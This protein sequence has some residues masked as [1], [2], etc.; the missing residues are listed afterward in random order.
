[1]NFLNT[2][3]Y[4]TAVCVFQNHT[5]QLSMLCLDMYFARS[6][7]NAEGICKWGLSGIMSH[8]E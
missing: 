3:G 6:L 2:K 1:M 4:M 8:N 7:V 5:V